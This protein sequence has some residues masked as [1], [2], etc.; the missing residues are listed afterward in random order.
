MSNNVQILSRIGIATTALAI[1]LA[2]ATALAQSADQE[3][4]TGDIIVTAN[5]T[6]SSLQDTPIAVT[7]L[8]DDDLI[9]Q[10]V[11]D[12][13]ALG[14]KVPGLNIG[15]TGQIFMR[16]VGTTNVTEVANGAVA[17]YLDGVYLARP[18]QMVTADLFD[19]ERVEALR[20]PQGTLY[21]RN[22]TAGSI[23]IITKKPTFDTEG[24]AAIQYGNY[25]TLIAGAVANVPLSD[26]IAI[27]ATAQSSSHDG[28]T[29]TANSIDNRAPD[30][31]S[32][33]TKKFRVQVLAEPTD[34]LS[35]LL[36]A[37]YLSD[38]NI[39]G[40][41]GVQRLPRTD[42][43]PERQGGSTNP[44]W[45]DTYGWGASAEVKLQT[46]IGELT[47]LGAHRVFKM[48]WLQDYIQFGG[49]N[50][51][52]EVRERGTFT[53]DQQELRLAGSAGPLDYITG[54]F[55]FKESGWI[56]AQ[57]LLPSGSY[58]V[59]DASDVGAES[60]AAYAQGT[61]HV[62]DALRLTGGVRYTHDEK[63]RFGSTY[64][65]DSDFELVGS[66][67]ENSAKGSW[68][69]VT[70]KLGA[71]FDITPD[72]MV[73]ASVSTGYN[74]GG[75]FDGTSDNI[76]GPENITAYE[77]G[78]KNKLFG[79]LLTANISAFYYQ[80]TDIQVPTYK[81]LENGA[82]SGIT[83]NA[84]KARIY[85]AELESQLRPTDNDSIDFAL[86]LLN[87]KY[88]SFYLPNGDTY[89]IAAATAIGS[90][91][92]TAD[93]SGNRLPR[94]PDVTMT[95]GYQH[96]FDLDSGATVTPRIQGHYESGKY[97]H[98]T[99]LESSWQGKYATGDA[100][101][102]YVSA[103]GNWT[104]MGY[105]RNITDR[106][107]YVDMEPT[108]SDFSVAYVNLNAPRTY[109]VRIGLKF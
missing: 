28:Y 33:D 48:N 74:A 88:T 68:E 85:G 50:G 2:P 83:L 72:S 77:V 30:Q 81:V 63:S 20:G 106:L 67:S 75:Y 79:G 59:T 70:W 86:S 98:Y 57:F 24:E 36:A 41:R 84:G 43:T 66:E 19:V 16:G 18:L 35:V 69:K 45:N 7:A 15:N 56:R 109:G 82:R 102:T 12:M 100:T 101:V 53:S 40:T 14:T 49:V 26:R 61:L 8:T 34:N 6:E 55:Y 71:D 29:P 91:D 46:G 64:L 54:V 1:G 22:A 23:N 89:S 95:L 9:Q 108:S 94:S 47:Y 60:Y 39:R 3:S 76:Y 27:R 5:R 17:T 96:V 78:S 11:T 93:Y 31:D 32:V 107:V 103:D 105:V 92:Y 87:T 65:L 10:G 37:D 99:N 90:T 38:G 42:G 62:G 51:A 52:G 80:F 4:D 13:T 97:Y 104:V 25:N 58:F 21:G 73:Y 44:A